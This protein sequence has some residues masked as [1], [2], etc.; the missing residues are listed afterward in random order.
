MD[1]IAF[2]QSAAS[3]HPDD[4]Q[5]RSLFA[6]ASI[7]AVVG[8]LECAAN[9][10]LDSLDLGKLGEDLDKLPFLSK[11]EIFARLRN[12]E[13]RNFRGRV[14]VERVL[15]LKRLRDALVHPKS[16][17]RSLRPKE[18]DFLEVEST[19]T[20]KLQISH[21]SE[22]WNADDCIA[23]LRA[24]D[25]FLSVV[26][27]ELAGLST[28]DAARALLTR[29]D[30]D[31]EWASG[32]VLPDHPLFDQARRDWRLAFSYLGLK[33]LNDARDDHVSSGTAR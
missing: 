23:A 5:A 3:T 16:A 8:A 20:E 19:T 29:V 18:G 10:A 6:R 22:R 32:P 26:L 1:A 25:D 17:V 24:A 33:P 21:F 9:L 2:A 30:L 28:W 14:E 11:L 7:Q 4:A 27:L 31:D 13:I 12:P 15:E